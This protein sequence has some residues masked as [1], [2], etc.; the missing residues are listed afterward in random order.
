MKAT[1]LLATPLYP[2]EGGGPATFAASL[3]RL[4]PE[5]GI[6]VSV[7]KFSSI[8]H[9]V[10]GIRHFAYARLLIR[11][12]RKLEKINVI[13]VL[14]PLS[15]GFPAWMASVWLRVPLVVRVVGDYAWEQGVQRAGIKD[16]LD[17]FLT[18][19]H[20]SPLVLL[21]QFVQSFVAK[22]ADAVVVPSK[23]LGSVVEKW[24]VP[25]ERVSLIYNGFK[26]EAPGNMNIREKLGISGKLV[27]SAGRFVP[28]KGFE[29]LATLVP[30]FLKN[31]PPA[32]LVIVGDG[33]MKGVLEEK[34]RTI[35]PGL[36]IVG[37]VSHRTLLG[38]LK[39]ADVFV[40][41]TGYE[42]FSHL[43]L[44]AMSVG[45]PVVTTTVGGNP[46]LI[47]DKEEGLLVS[48]N[49]TRALLDSVCSLLSEST[50]RT[51]LIQTARRTASQFTEERMAQEYATLI[52]S[53]NPR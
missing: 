34:A 27:I 48:Y 15:T 11:E 17:V 6:N 46:E 47:R 52:G 1:V 16:V 36:K 9:L 21:L 31:D 50:M 4:L 44:E 20:Y 26:R 22:R 28:W 12:A 42:G 39:D 41:N 53:F 51:R 23:Y 3:E 2:P 8:R 10:W 7:V 5:H 49:D 25:R 32:T 24:G 19:R 37:G 29:A 18:T 14:D 38:F 40:L 45:V 30:S 33:P 43:I 13:L 35:G